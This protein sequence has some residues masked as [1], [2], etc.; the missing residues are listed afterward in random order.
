MSL[1]ELLELPEE[2]ALLAV[3]EGPGDGLG[4]MALT[5]PVL[6]SFIEVV[7]TGRLSRAQA[8]PRKPTRTDAA[9]A[10]GLIDSILTE[11]EVAL[12]GG[13]DLS[14]AGGFRYASFLPDARPLGL[15]L[16]DQAY[17]VLTVALTFATGAGARQGEVL[18]A[19]PARGRAKAEASAES[20]GAVGL[21]GP[22]GTHQPVAMDWNDAM[23]G[24]SFL[25]KPI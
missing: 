5:P 2:L 21:G 25:P 3:V 19:L 18:L 1:T 7:T 12:A 22:T 8:Q 24:Q 9:M 17:R 15:I 13:A 14:W 20:A 23:E 4:L 10:A 6:A 16:D 11:L